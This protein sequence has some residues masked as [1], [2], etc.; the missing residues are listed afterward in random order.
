M[1]SWFIPAFITWIILAPLFKWL[2]K[3]NLDDFL[4]ISLIYW[5]LH[6]L[7]FMVL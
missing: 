6:L 3:L 7:L 5:F 2:F 1:I 4:M